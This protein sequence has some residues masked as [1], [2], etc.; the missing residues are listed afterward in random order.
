MERKKHHENV[1]KIRKAIVK[2][3]K[4]WKGILITITA[5]DTEE[6]KTSNIPE[7]VEKVKDSFNV[8]EHEK[9]ANMTTDAETDTQLYKNININIKDF[10]IPQSICG[11]REEA[12]NASVDI[13]VQEPNTYNDTSFA[14]PCSESTKEILQKKN[15]QKEHINQLWLVLLVQ[16]HW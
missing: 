14:E 5:A 8:E 4:D 11:S 10:K 2:R 6:L 3:F 16:F 9:T 7:N 13:S 12:Y 1:K 15:H